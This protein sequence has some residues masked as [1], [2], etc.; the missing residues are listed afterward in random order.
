MFWLGHLLDAAAYLALPAK[1]VSGAAKLVTHLDLTVDV[2]VINVA[3]PG[4]VSFIADLQKA[5]NDVRVIGVLNDS[6]EMAHIPKVNAIHFKGFAMDEA[7]KSDWLQC[8]REVL[9]PR[10]ATAVPLT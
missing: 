7:A 3:L 1:S 9:T 2:L 4:G 8:V 6:V 5:N 10:A